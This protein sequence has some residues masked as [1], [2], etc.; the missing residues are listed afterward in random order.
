MVASSSESAI[1]SFT[2]EKCKWSLK[3]MRVYARIIYTNPKKGQP[4]K[5]KPELLSVQ[6][7][8]ASI[9]A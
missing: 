4:H 9:R 7:R 3:T 5:E 1:R 8:I 6:I 2:A